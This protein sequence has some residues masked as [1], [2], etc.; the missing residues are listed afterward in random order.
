MARQKFFRVLCLLVFLPFLLFAN[1]SGAHAAGGIDF[2]IGSATKIITLPIDLMVKAVYFIANTVKT[3]QLKNYDEN[4]NVVWN[5]EAQQEIKKAGLDK[6]L[7]NYKN[8]GDKLSDDYANTALPRSAIFRDKNSSAR[9]VVT[10]G[11][12]LIESLN[13]ETAGMG[14]APSDMQG[15]G[16]E[17]PL[18]LKITDKAKDLYDAAKTIFSNNKSENPQPG[19]VSEGLEKIIQKPEVSTKPND[20]ALPLTPTPAIAQS[21]TVLKQ[22]PSPNPI[23]PQDKPVVARTIN[24]HYQTD[25]DKNDPNFGPAPIPIVLLNWDLS[26]E[27]LTSQTI[28]RDN[29]VLMS[30]SA[31]TGPA[32]EDGTIKAGETYNYAVKAMYGDGYSSYAEINVAV[33]IDI[34]GNPIQNVT[35]TPLISNPTPTPTNTPTST[36]TQNTN[37]VSPP[38]P[39]P[40]PTPTVT[41]TPIPTPKPSTV[42]QK[43]TLIINIV[44]QNNTPFTG[45]KFACKKTDSNYCTVNN[46]S[47]NDGQLTASG[48]F[49]DGEKIFIQAN[50][51][52]TNGSFSTVVY[53]E[54]SLYSFDININNS[55][56]SIVDLGTITLKRW[57]KISAYLVDN[58]G[59]TI[60][61]AVYECKISGT[62]NNSGDLAKLWDI[63]SFS[64]S[65]QQIYLN[66]ANNKLFN[67]P[68]PDGNYKLRVDYWSQTLVEKTFEIKNEISVDLGKI[69]VPLQ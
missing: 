60:K 14:N 43:D 41:L 3:S 34:C 53:P 51:I 52:S 31:S 19:L 48:I 8:S 37:I 9:K 54:S 12:D 20:N 59:N 1:P 68:L 36:P 5:K 10:S 32:Y 15:V 13:G 65:G 38:S 61:Y 46:Y 16:G 64:I 57:G 42:S 33:P 35:P 2:I 24:L 26:H 6:T 4:D 69:E 23:S 58:A 67:Y 40:S 63:G 50:S 56:N 49:T 27:N 45:M 18:W 62:P 25:C 21:P 47:Y 7:E 17:K 39:T 29:K 11:K 28:Y 55:T 22:T 66:C 44:D 30:V